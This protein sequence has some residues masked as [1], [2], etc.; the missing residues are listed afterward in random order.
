MFKN[1]IIRIKKFLCIY[2]YE[3]KRAK[4]IYEQIKPED[5]E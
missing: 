4:I 1:I 2:C 5:P 3:D